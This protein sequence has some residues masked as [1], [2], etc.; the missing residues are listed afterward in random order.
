MLSI[1]ANILWHGVN[2]D[3]PQHGA[4]LGAADGQVF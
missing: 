3:S 1:D 4:A 2:A